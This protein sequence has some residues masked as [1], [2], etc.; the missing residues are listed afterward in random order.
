[1]TA[2]EPFEQ[3]D[4]AISATDLCLNLRYPTAGETSASLLRIL[5]VGR[6]VVVSDYADFGD[7][8]ADLSVHIPPGE[9][10]MQKLAAALAQLLDDRSRLARMGEAARRYVADVHAPERAAD[11]L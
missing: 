1:M 11:E 9:G 2:P 4:A 6:P 7:L 10:E 5:A 3:L 8:P